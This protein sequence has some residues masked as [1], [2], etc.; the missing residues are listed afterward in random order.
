MMQLRDKQLV[1][2]AVNDNQDVS[3]AAGGSHW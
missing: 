1:C 3:K 2:L